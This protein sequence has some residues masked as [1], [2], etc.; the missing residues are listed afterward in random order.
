MADSPA[1][2]ADSHDIHVCYG[3]LFDAKAQL[4]VRHGL[5]IHSPPWSRFS[6]LKVEPDSNIYVLIYDDGSTERNIGISD[7]VTTHHLQS[8]KGMLGVRFAAVVQSSTLSSHINK[9]KPSKAIIDISV[10]IYGPARLIDQVGL[11]L[12]AVSAFLQHPV[13]LE[14]GLEYVNPHFFYPD[15]ERYEV[16]GLV[17]P[18]SLDSRALG[19]S[20]GIENALSSLDDVNGMLESTRQMDMTDSERRA[21][22]LITTTLT[23]SVVSFS[24]QEVAVNFIRLR[25]DYA[26][27]RTV[28]SDL[29]TLIGHNQ[30]PTQNALG[31]IVADV[32]GLGKTLTML[33]AIVQAKYKAVEFELAEDSNNADAPRLSKATLIIVTSRR[34]IH[35]RP[36]ALDVLVFHGDRRAKIAEELTGHDVVLTTYHTLTSDWKKRSGVLQ[37]LLWYRVILDEAHWIRNQ[38]SQQF[39]AAVALR[40]ERRWCLS[41]TPIQNSVHDFRSLLTFLR[42]EPFSTLSAF[43][44]YILKPIRDESP[45]SFR[46]LRLLLRATCIRR[47][48]SHLNLP[49]PVVQ[50]VDVDLSREEQK[51]YEDT[52]KDCE[53]EF[54]KIVSTNNEAKKNKYSVLFTTI[55]KLRRLCNHGVAN[56]GLCELCGGDDQDT[57]AL[58]DGISQCPDCS[59]DLGRKQANSLLNPFADSPSP[60]ALSS[61]SHEP[62]IGGR[63]PRSA[64]EITPLSSGSRN[65][66]QM[67][68]SSKLQA[69]VQNIIASLPGSKSYITARSIV[70]TSWRDTIDMIGPMLTYHN[71]P[72]LRIDGRVGFSDRMSIISRFQDT[73]EACVLV[74]SI[75]TGA[76]GLTLTAATRVHVVEPQWNPSVEDQAIARALR[77]G[78]ERTVTVVRYIA[79]GTLEEV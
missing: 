33:S 26:S 72:Y 35:L 46:N 22:E 47:G 68:G 13:Y 57:Q 64:G 4:N 55:M 31:G 58:L 37:K 29:H 20:N 60:Y 11:K 73:D 9:K 14:T 63:S 70:F 65:I 28:A 21:A 24:Y 71:I 42:F 2:T 62:S 18:P 45:D 67:T 5:V 6:T 32:M 48:L 74:M 7:L 41:G 79:K 36:G 59:R 30:F 39:K 76:V 69:V 49:D 40:T 15:S 3:T 56:L 50:K 52:L 34:K 25:E 38:S 17:G 10:N 16:R 8:L 75:G 53:N 77:K 78:Q 43:D 44:R 54:D 51:L 23:R 66:G 1:D 19:I 61:T 27:C 12:E